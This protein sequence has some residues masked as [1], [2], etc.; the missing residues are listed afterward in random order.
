MKLIK[1][2]LPVAVWMGIIFFFSSRP[3]IPVSESYTISFVIFKT[4]HLIEY[5]LLYILL[6]RAMRNSG[7]KIQAK[8][9]FQALLVAILYAVTDEIHQVF[10]PTR[11]GR[12]RDVAIDSIG[13]SV[14]AYYIWKLL[15]QAPKPLVNLAK[16]LA[17]I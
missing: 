4:L 6:Y 17:I 8:F 16:K 2:W 5:S 7:S 3:R 9:T 12:L 13:I 11:E 1:Y 15:P 10:V 14:T